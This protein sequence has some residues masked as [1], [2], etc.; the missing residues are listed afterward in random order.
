M[1]HLK[2]PVLGLSLAAL[3]VA[4]FA[5]LKPSQS[6]S[7]TSAQANAV[8]VRLVFAQPY[9]VVEPYRFAWMHQDD[10]P[11]VSS[12]WIVGVSTDPEIADVKQTHDELLFVGDV[13]VERI[14]VGSESG[15]VIGFV[16]SPLDETGEPTLDL[17]TAPIYWSKPEILPESLRA[18]DAKT[19]LAEAVERGATAQTEAAV[20]SAREAGGHVVD[21]ETL[22]ELYRYAAAQLLTRYSPEE[23]DLI[24]GLTAEKLY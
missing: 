10:A 3:S 12:G 8:P 23:V 6:A 1:K 5:A 18:S 21:V 16:P 4:G 7:V 24:S 15:I 17:D 22:G 20:V 19:V 2:L 9:R 13:P 14:N 11:M